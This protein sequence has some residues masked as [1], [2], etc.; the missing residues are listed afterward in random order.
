MGFTSGA[1]VN[2]KI[3]ITKKIVCLP[4]AISIGKKCLNNK[5]MIANEMA[6]PVFFSTMPC[7]IK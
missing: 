3:A 5:W 7:K 4:R 2:I 6:A 1:A